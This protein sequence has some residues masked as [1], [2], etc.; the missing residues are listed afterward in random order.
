MGIPEF[1]V[2]GAIVLFR[3]VPMILLLWAAVTVYKVRKTQNDMR[4]RLEHLE[5]TLPRQ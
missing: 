4:V 5:Q 1:M 3:I 2:I